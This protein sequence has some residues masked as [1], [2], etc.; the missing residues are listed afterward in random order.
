MPNVTASEKYAIAAAIGLLFLV[1]FEDARLMLAV[2]TVGLA[3]GLWL[4]RR[5]EVRR[6]AVVALAACAIAAVFAVFTLLR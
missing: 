2:S 3:A 1:L 5:G 6:V 4:A